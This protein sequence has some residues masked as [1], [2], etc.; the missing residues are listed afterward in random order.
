MPQRFL[1]PSSENSRDKYGTALENER[2]GVPTPEVAVNKVVQK[3]ETGLGEMEQRFNSALDLLN[4]PKEKLEQLGS[5]ISNK[6]NEAVNKLNPISSFVQNAT[7]TISNDINQAMQLTSNLAG[8]ATLDKIAAPIKNAA[9][10]VTGE[11]N[12]ITGLANQVASIP[13]RL[14]NMASQALSSLTEHGLATAGAT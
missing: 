8:S 9:G 5:T 13:S 7:N 3:V 10:E 6:L 12:K 2:K 14:G 1:L 11:I 4:K